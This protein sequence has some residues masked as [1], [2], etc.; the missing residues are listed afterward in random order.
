MY[1]SFKESIAYA[2]VLHV[3]TTLI[4]M[5]S[6]PVQIHPT[7]VID[8]LAPLLLTENEL[9]PVLFSGRCGQCFYSFCKH[10]C[11]RG[12]HPRC[13]AN[14]WSILWL[15]RRKVAKENKSSLRE[16]RLRT[17]GNSTQDRK[18]IEWSR[19]RTSPIVFRSFERQQAYKILLPVTQIYRVCITVFY[20][21]YLLWYT[22]FRSDVSATQVQAANEILKLSINNPRIR[23]IFL[24]LCT[25]DQAKIIQK[26]CWMNSDLGLLSSSR[27]AL[28]CVTATEV[29]VI[30]D[31]L[32]GMGEPVSPCKMEYM[33]ELR[34]KLINY[35][36]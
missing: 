31:K 20:I 13:W 30:A 29:N 27:K 17:S 1:H 7:T 25:N 21:S 24:R 9:R 10:K 16:A 4:S 19:S 26:S 6:K 33:Q 28:I 2:S 35:L 8:R 14:N 34:Q 11:Y 22:L 32:Y 15:C 3:K 23:N 12:Q 36:T 5:P 18:D